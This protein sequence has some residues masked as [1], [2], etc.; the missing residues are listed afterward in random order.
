MKNQTKLEI[1]ISCIK[2]K[3]N[4]VASRIDKL[5]DQRDAAATIMCDCEEKEDTDSL[6][7]ENAEDDY[8]HAVDKIKILSNVLDGLEELL[9]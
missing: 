9:T 1:R 6:K 2:I 4:Q 5:I 7:Y 8:N 3:I